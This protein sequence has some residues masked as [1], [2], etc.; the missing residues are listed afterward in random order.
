VDSQNV[1]YDYALGHF[2]LQSSTTNQQSDL[3][4]N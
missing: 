2:G 4:M 1:T 3:I